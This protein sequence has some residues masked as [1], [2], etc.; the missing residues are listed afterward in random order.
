MLDSDPESL[1]FTAPDLRHNIFIPYS[2]L[3]P[4]FWMIL[5]EEL[6]P[7]PPPPSSTSSYTRLTDASCSHSLY[8][9][10]LSGRQTLCI[11]G[12]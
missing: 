1:K 5:S 7:P 4:F 11:Q 9:G 2:A 12:V 8:S 6:A 10:F 3:L